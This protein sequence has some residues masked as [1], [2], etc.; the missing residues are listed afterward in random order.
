[1]N[2]PTLAFES[3]PYTAGIPPQL[4]V[5][6][7]R[8]ASPAV[9]GEVGAMEGFTLGVVHRGVGVIKAAGKTL[10]APAG[11]GLLFPTGGGYRVEHRGCDGHGPCATTVSLRYRSPDPGSA[12]R[13]SQVS[14]V[15]Q[16][17]VALG[18]SGLAV[19]LVGL[20]TRL[21]SGDGFPIVRGGPETPSAHGRAA[22]RPQQRTLA[23]RALEALASRI[24]EPLDLRSLARALYCSPNHLCRSFRRQTG[25]TLSS[26][27]RRMRVGHAMLRLL[28]GQSDLASLACDLG[29]ASHSHFSA[30][31]RRVIGASPSAFRDW[32]LRDGWAEGGQA[33]LGRTTP[34]PLSEVRAATPAARAVM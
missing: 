29:F 16:E 12:S 5:R 1:M 6:H 10:E 17:P 33:S 11:S 27:L 19:T 31:F 30:D 4:R 28:A 32:S 14:A 8:C 3:P 22:P 24:S 34:R 7:H 25:S 20:I 15:S 26:E 21:R 13:A 18:P 23:D 2:G 9:A